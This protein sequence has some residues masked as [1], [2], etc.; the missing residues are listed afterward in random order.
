[1]S[2]FILNPLTLKPSGCLNIFTNTPPPSYSQ[3]PSETKLPESFKN[4]LISIL[5]FFRGRLE[6]LRPNFTI[7]NNLRKH[8]IDQKR[9]KFQLYFLFKECHHNM[10]Q[11][12][13]P[14][15]AN[16]TLSEIFAIM[17]EASQ[18]F[19][20]EDYSVNQTSLDNVSIHMLLFL[21]LRCERL[22]TI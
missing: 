21:C 15:S 7:K 17:E 6:M 5:Y 11:Y 9:C 18:Q 12:Q 13:I 2:E 16:R 3:F 8:E 20:I 10:V 14:S 19:E 1:M 22:L 4:F